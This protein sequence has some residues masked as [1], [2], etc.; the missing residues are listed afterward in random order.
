MSVT[1]AIMS[2]P[3]RIEHIYE[4]EVKSKFQV[5]VSPELGSYLFIVKIE[6]R[7]YVSNV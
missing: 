2:E 5:I 7:A 6:N 3:V 4:I 1:A